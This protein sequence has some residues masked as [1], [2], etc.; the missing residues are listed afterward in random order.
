MVHSA[1]NRNFWIMLIA[2]ASLIS[3]VYYL[4]HYIRFDGNIPQGHL[5]TWSLTA[6][7]IV[8][9]KLVSL[10]IFDM[11]RGMWRYA[12]IH[13]M[14][15]IV[16][17][18]LISSCIIMAII[19]IIYRFQGFSRGV[20]IIDFLLT[21]VFLGG[22]RMSVRLYY[23]QN[24]SGKRVFFSGKARS[25]IKKILI[26]GAGRMGES[27]LREIVQNSK[28]YYEVTGFI[29][30]DPF[31]MNQKIH[32]IPVLGI[33]QD[34]EEIVKQYAVDEIII[35]ISSASAIQM[36][37][38]VNLCKSVDVPFKTMPNMQELLEGRLNLTTIR[39]VRYE[40]LLGREP[41]CLD[42]K[43]IGDCLTDKNVM[44]TGGAGSI[45]SEL[46]RQ[47]ALF[48]PEKLI[49]VDQSESG[50][51]DMEL[52][53]LA[54]FPGLKITPVLA[55]VQKKQFMKRIFEKHKP[56]VVL[57]AAAYK[58]VPM[59]ELHPWEAVF[60]NVIG[61]RNILELCHKHNVDR[62]VL[63][64]TDKSVRPTNI[65]G[66]SKRIAELLTQCYTAK[67]KARFM[68]VR[69]GNVV[70]SVGSVIPLFKKQIE[71][72]GPVTVTHPEVTRYFMTIPE[73]CSLI[74]QA[75]AIGDGGEI[76]ILKM[77]VPVRIADMARDMITLSG[78]EPGRDI[79][80]EYVGLRPG[81]KLY[82]ELVTFGED[83][84]KTDHEDI[85]VLNTK[86]N[87]SLE[88]INTCLETLAELAQDGDITG[89]KKQFKKIVPEYNP[90]F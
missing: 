37:R 41:V 71:R 46:C 13:D 45:G 51:Y 6:T 19:I 59:M 1:I 33:L 24:L 85:M 11:Y 78:Y 82:E 35:A 29:D 39:N 36:R 40:D 87:K 48:K 76:F 79:E 34:I 18:C 16:K 8:F 42:M 53:L 70:G 90:Q 74:L 49:I 56:D 2:D 89:I 25:N 30:D 62:F 20:F 47:I 55:S 75:G 44:V 14:I 72:G 86:D 28:I 23:T 65:M 67:N 58:H 50:L 81:E 83:I 32:G 77:G 26:I 73:A 80:I 17:A 63:V 7:W 12:S 15:N 68:A 64:S 88:E 43:Q 52:G 4:A 31:K 10:F 60:N 38:I 5:T 84:L 66:A 9:I 3:F 27:L 54:S 22:F 21:L 57:H 69:F 61:T